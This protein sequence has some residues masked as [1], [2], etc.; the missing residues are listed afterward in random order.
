MTSFSFCAGDH[1]LIYSGPW[2]A[3]FPRIGGNP[4][5]YK[6]HYL[7]RVFHYVDS[8]AHQPAGCFFLSARAHHHQR[9][10]GSGRGPI[11]QGHRKRS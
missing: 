3:R 5:S 1:L 8:Q 2:L 11:A 4:E 7:G 9:Q 10:L 6:S